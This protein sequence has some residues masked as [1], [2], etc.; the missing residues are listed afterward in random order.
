MGW[1]EYARLIEKHNIDSAAWENARKGN[2]N[3]PEHALKNA[4][5]HVLA[6]DVVELI[7]KLI[8]KLA[9]E[10]LRGGTVGKF[11][12][13][14]AVVVTQ[15][16]K[17]LASEYVGSIGTIDYEYPNMTP[18]RYAVKFS[19]DD[20]LAIDETYLEAVT[21]MPNTPP[22]SQPVE[23]NPTTI[24]AAEF[25]D[26]N[27]AAKIK[28]KECSVYF[29]GGHVESVERGITDTSKYLVTHRLVEHAWLDDRN[30]LKVVWHDTPPASEP[31]PDALETAN[32]LIEQL[33][34]DEKRLIL[35]R[36]ALKRQ[37]ADALAENARL[38][39]QAT[40][41]SIA[42]AVKYYLDWFIDQKEVWLSGW[43]DDD[44]DIGFIEYLE[45]HVGAAEYES[46]LLA[47]ISAADTVFRNV[48]PG[49][50]VDADLLVAAGEP[51]ATLWRRWETS[52]TDDG[53][54]FRQWLVDWLQHSD[55]SEDHANIAFDADWQRLDAALAKAK[56]KGE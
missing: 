42:D 39:T 46:R 55:Y 7:M 40:M 17:V 3:T 41:P 27:Y 29:C 4:L 26:G 19:E 8:D 52:G 25:V 14:Q 35:E 2:P 44:N 38:R 47:L 1:F 37:L 13:G 54:L 11:T 6:E 9:D 12:I 36:D 21:D 31:A 33:H 10:T 48:T 51:F 34:M 45:E 5:E 53:T 50:A 49:P 20:F 56:A 32:S 18:P 43:N 22:V 24:T 16:Y 28:A 23:R 15:E 30:T